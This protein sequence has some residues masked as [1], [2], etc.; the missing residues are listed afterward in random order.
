[1]SWGRGQG[2]EGVGVDDDA[3]GGVE[4]ADEVF[5]GGQVDGDFAAD[6]AVDLGE[7]G[8]GDLDEGD[9]AG[10]GGGDEADEVAGDS[11]AEGDEG[12]AALGALGGEPVV[13]VGGDVEGF[14]FL[15][16][17]EGVGFGRGG[18]RR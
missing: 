14:A 4:G 5:A 16:G 17:R 11:A 3:V 10:V 7:Q 13:E 2:G 12:F 8:G 18:L 1:M 6:A 15:A 9:A